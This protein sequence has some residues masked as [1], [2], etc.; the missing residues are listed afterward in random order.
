MLDHFKLCLV[1]LATE[2]AGQASC[3][4][5][6]FGPAFVCH[7]HFAEFVFV[8]RRGT[9]KQ[10]Q[11]DLVLGILAVISCYMQRRR[12]ELVIVGA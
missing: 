10:L 7:S 6:P 3:L 9:G 8:D 4:I 5:P 2:R 1:V 11:N 12:Q